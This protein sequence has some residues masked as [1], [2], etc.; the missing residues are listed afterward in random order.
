[1]TSSPAFGLVGGACV[2]KGRFRIRWGGWLPLRSLEYC[3]DP[4]FRVWFLLR[5]ESQ[6]IEVGFGAFVV[7]CGFDDFIEHPQPLE[8]FQF[9]RVQLHLL[10]DLPSNLHWQPLQKKHQPIL[11]RESPHLYQLRRH[12]VKLIDV[13][14]HL[15]LVLP[16]VSVHC[17]DFDVIDR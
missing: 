14:F 7:K 17:N 8:G 12:V 6:S 15:S 11:P 3:Q 4:L 2:G 5:T 10:L 16:D 9:L 13:V 1:M